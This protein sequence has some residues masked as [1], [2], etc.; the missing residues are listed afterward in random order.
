MAALLGDDYFLVDE[1]TA[2]KRIPG[3]DSVPLDMHVVLHTLVRFVCVNNPGSI[4]RSEVSLMPDKSLGVAFF[5][6]PTPS[7]PLR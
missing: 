2:D 3:W 5:S 7:P 4:Y 6:R 1:H